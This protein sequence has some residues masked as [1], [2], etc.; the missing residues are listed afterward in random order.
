[1]ENI[2]CLNCSNYFGDLACQAFPSI[3][4]EEILLDKNDHSKPLKD[5]DNDIVFEPIEKA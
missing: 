4:P 3:I 2:R 5:Q 1:M